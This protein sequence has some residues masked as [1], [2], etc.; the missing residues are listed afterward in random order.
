M[1]VLSPRNIRYRL[2]SSEKRRSF[3]LASSCPWRAKGII[4]YVWNRGRLARGDG[5]LCILGARGDDLLSILGSRREC[6]LSILGTKSLL[7]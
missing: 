4:L 3:R 2:H 5:L 1:D 7:S 6:W